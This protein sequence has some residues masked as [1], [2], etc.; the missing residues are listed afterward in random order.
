[1][2]INVINVGSKVHE[3]DLKEY[4]SDL[5]KRISAYAQINDL[6]CKNEKQL[7]HILKNLKNVIILDV[8]GDTL[9]S[10][11]FAMLLFE[12]TTF[13]IGP[14]D[15]FS[16]YTK[17]ELKK[18]YKF[19]SLSNLTLPHRLCRAILL[20]QIYRGFCIINNHPYAK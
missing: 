11:Q 17:E 6:I 4:C 3:K 2:K 12:D 13:V 19:I 16:K 20:E 5:K 1:V 10:N 14:H 7:Y 9:N 15:G 8:E 18:K